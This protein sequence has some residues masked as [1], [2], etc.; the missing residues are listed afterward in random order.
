MKYL[1]SVTGSLTILFSPCR[2]C[3]F[4]LSLTSQCPCPTGDVSLGSCICSSLR[5]RIFCII[6]AFAA[7]VVSLLMTKISFSCGSEASSPVLVSWSSVATCPTRLCC[8]CWPNAAW[9]DAPPSNCCYFRL[10]P[11]NTFEFTAGDAVA[12]TVYAHTNYC[13]CQ[14]LPSPPEGSE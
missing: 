7:L 14:W 8:S 9:P 1:Q 10:Q 4:W 5:L 2:C 12:L 13:V 3:L 6:F 11:S